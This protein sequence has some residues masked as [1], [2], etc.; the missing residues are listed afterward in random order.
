[1]IHLHEKGTNKPL[2]D[3]SEA[4]LQFLTDR[5]EEEWLE[6]HDYAITSLVVDSF[7]AEGADPALVTLLRNALAG[8]DEIEIIWSR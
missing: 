5:L 8:R 7:E 2:G 4:Q 3:I 1:M 6:D